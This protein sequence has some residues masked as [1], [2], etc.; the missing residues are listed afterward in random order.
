MLGWT[1]AAFL[2]SMGA[3]LLLIPGF[4]MKIAAQ[5]TAGIIGLVGGLSYAFLFRAIG[6]KVDRR[7]ILVLSVTWA[8]SF[9]FGI[10][11]LFHTSGSAPAMMTLTFCSFAVFGALGGMVTARLLRS[12][13]PVVIA[14]D[15]MPSIGIWSFSFGLAAVASNVVGEGLEMFL[16]E[17]IAWFIA[18]EAMALIIGGAGGY[19]VVRFLRTEGRGND[20]PAE[21]AHRSS[22]GESHH[23]Y[24]IVLM[25]LCL[26]FYLNDFSDIYVKDWR[27]WLAIDYVAVKLFPFLVVFG[28]IHTKKMEFSAFGLN[29]QPAG[30]FLAVCFIGTLSAIFLE[31]S[32]CL[33]PVGSNAGD[34]KSVLALA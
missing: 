26:P 34:R 23:P 10:T 5:A 8:L 25:M 21:I 29:H 17:W 30:A 24:F 3:L 22:L 20:A 2:G 13:H 16:P 31:Q 27:L 9:V 15:F 12:V 14:R 1:I 32:S 7:H 19:S 18:F 33:F 6:G 11:P 4:P 28:L